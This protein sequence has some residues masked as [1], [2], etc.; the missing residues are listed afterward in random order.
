MDGT[1]GALKEH[2]TTRIITI[3]RRLQFI[4]KFSVEI[5]EKTAY[6]QKQETPN[7]VAQNKDYFAGGGLRFTLQWSDGPSEKPSVPIE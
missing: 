3:V 4:Q 1:I 7:L 6:D 5:R 2:N